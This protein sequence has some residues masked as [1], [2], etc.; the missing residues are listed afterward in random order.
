MTDLPKIL[1]AKEL[2]AHKDIKDLV[3]KKFQRTGDW[4]PAGLKQNK[5]FACFGKEYNENKRI[6]RNN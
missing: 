4:M 5:Y 1:R 3:F 6:Q 2:I